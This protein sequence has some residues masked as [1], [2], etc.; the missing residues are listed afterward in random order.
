[1][2]KKQTIAT[3]FF[4]LAI[5]YIISPW[6][7]EKKLLFNEILSVSGLGLLV[8]KRFKI[9]RSEIA[10]YIILLLTLCAVHLITSL[11]RMDGFY[12]YL[13]NSVI[14]YSMFTFFLGYFTFRY[15]DRFLVKVRKLLSLYIGFFLVV[16]V[17][18]FLFE[19]FGMSILFPSVLH[20]RNLRYGLPILILLCILYS[21]FYSSATIVI[22][23]IF[24]MMLLIIPGYKVAKQMGFIILFVFIGFFIAIQPDLALM[25]RYSV[26]TTNGIE[27]VMGSNAL[28]E[29]DASTTWRFLFWRQAIVDQ[30]PYNLAGI[31]FGTPLFRFFPVYDIEKLDTLPYVMGAHNSFV[32]L[33]ARLGILF[34]V[35]IL[36]VYRVIFK[37]YFSYKS[38]YYKNRSILL[39]WSFF[40]VSIIAFF[41][42]VLESPI[43]ASAYW[44]VLGMLAKAIYIRK[45]TETL[46]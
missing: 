43:Y 8:Y 11:W 14:I 1:M 38:F 45:K 29:L 4:L 6:F 12:Y 41:N 18:S 5:C 30:F 24:Y 2:I 21:L 27:A 42:P 9:E 46:N 17:S 34:V 19:R 33:F 40:A 25:E 23:F 36:G 15:L 39:F 35:L 10:F 7:F 28:L 22:L 31:G 20:R 3:V 32:Y 13:R 26:L 37:E 44:L 16:P